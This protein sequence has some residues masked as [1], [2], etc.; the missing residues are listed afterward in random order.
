[1]RYVDTNTRHADD[2]LG[3]WLEEHVFDQELAALRWQ[4]GFFGGEILEY[5][6]PSIA[7]LRASSGPLRVLIGS[8][9]G[10][11]RSKDVAQLL[12][13]AGPPRAEQRVGVVSFTGGF[14]HPKTIHITR[15]DGSTAAYVGSANLTKNGITSVNIEAGVLLDT[16]DGDDVNCI[17][18]VAAAVDWWFAGDREGMTTVQGSQDIEALITAGVLDRPAPPPVAPTEGKLNSRHGSRLK[19]LLKLPLPIPAAGVPAGPAAAAAAAPA[20]LPAREWTKKLSASDAQR[21]K[22]GNQ[23]G[24]ITL[25][26]AG[27]NID[28][29]TYFRNEFFAGEPWVKGTTFTGVPRETATVAFHTMVLGTDLGT[30]PL[31][32]S[33]APNREAHQSNYTSLLHI[34]GISDQFRNNDLTDKWLQLT[35]DVT[36][37][38]ALTISDADPR[39]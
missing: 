8:N 25:V 31:M 27:Y 19:P 9:N 24:S 37:R 30:I 4:A 21:K 16:R 26:Q 28:A 7:Y 11:T 32:V 13:L 39:T 34:E 14:Y 35:E 2:A 18:D 23:R 3:S 29:Q 22:T 17:A 12:Q 20:P 38:F 36:G 33:Y 5:F 15:A 1:M 10:V 6:A